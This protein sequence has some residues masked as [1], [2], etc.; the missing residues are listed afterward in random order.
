MASG[1]FIRII[2]KNIW[3]VIVTTIICT[4]VAFYAD[5][6]YRA[7]SYTASANFLVIN[8]VDLKEEYLNNELEAHGM[9]IKD[10]KEIIESRSFLKKVRND[11]L[12][13]TPS[14]KKL[15]VGDIAAGLSIVNKNETRIV[16]INVTLGNP[17]LAAKI[18]NMIVKD[19]KIKAA[20]ILKVENI[21]GIDNAEV[22]ESPS[23]PNPKK[24][25]S[26]AAAVG[27]MCG[28]GIIYIK[29]LLSS[30]QPTQERKAD[31]LSF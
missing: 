5:F 2:I 20:E 27:M 28:L 23:S 11:L 24:D 8:R 6:F 7:E 12:I 25:V 18:A 1:S 16:N 21:I 13:N 30:S 15:S 4:G 9:L 31:G 22:P 17:V 19:F 14:I 10:Y 3:I 26:L 29:N